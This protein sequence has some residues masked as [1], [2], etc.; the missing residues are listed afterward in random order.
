MKNEM[1]QQTETFAELEYWKQRCLMA[2]RFIDESPCDP[3]ITPEQINAY[4]NWQ[5]FVNQENKK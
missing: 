3:D 5:Y 4:A 1:E 2:E